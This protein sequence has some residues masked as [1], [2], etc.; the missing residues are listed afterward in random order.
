MDEKRKN[1]NI[2]LKEINQYYYNKTTQVFTETENVIKNYL[3]Y[4]DEIKDIKCKTV[5]EKL[6]QNS[7]ESVFLNDKNQIS[8]TYT[9]NDYNYY[10]EY[11]NCSVPFSNEKEKIL[12]LKKNFVRLNNKGYEI[13][14]IDCENKYIKG[15]DKYTLDDSRYCLLN[16]TNNLRFNF[17]SYHNL[18]DISVEEGER[19][20]SKIL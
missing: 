12:L 13:C 4:I 19:F 9:T 18:L 1:F 17:K 14:V 2:L 11:E 8:Y 20:I 3:K 15:N 5:F 6:K 7:E 16:C 10:D